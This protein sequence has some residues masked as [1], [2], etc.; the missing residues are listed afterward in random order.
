MRLAKTDRARAALQ[1]R[2]PAISVT[3]RRVLILCD[4]QRGDADIVGLLGDAAALRFE[5]HAGA[6][7]VAAQRGH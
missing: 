1:A 2:D 7:Q 6:R 5:L 4:G 3:E